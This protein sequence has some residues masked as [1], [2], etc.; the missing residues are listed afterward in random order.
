MFEFALI[1]LQF[2]DDPNYNIKVFGV[3]LTYCKILP[4]YHNMRLEG[5]DLSHLYRMRKSLTLI[6]CLND[7]R[8][9]VV[10]GLDNRRQN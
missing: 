7:K 6:P 3:F 5:I 10:L 9:R 8:L 4:T 1:Y 2:I